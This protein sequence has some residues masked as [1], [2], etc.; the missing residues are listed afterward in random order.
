MNLLPSPPRQPFARATLGLLAFAAIVHL[1]YQIVVGLDRTD[2]GPFETVLARAVAGH[3][4]QGVG[5]SGFY[6]PFGGE[7]PSVLIHAP[8]Y[9]RMVAVLAWPLVQLGAEPLATV[10][11]SGRLLAFLGTLLLMACGAWLVR[12]DGGSRRAGW[13]AIGLIAASP[14]L[15][16]LA[17]ML[18]PDTL[19]VAFQTLGAWLVLQT[20]WD[21]QRAMPRLLLAYVAFALAFGIKQQNLTSA[22]VC[23]MLLALAWWRGRLKLGPIVLGH[24]AAVVVVAADLVIENLLTGGR[25]YHSVFVYPGGPFRDLNYAGWVHVRSVFNITAR[26][27]VGLI[28]LTVACLWATREVVLASIRAWFRPERPESKPEARKSPSTAQLPW[29]RTIQERSF[30]ALD[31]LDAV[32][33]LFLLVEVVA[34][35]PLCLFNAGAAANYALQATIFA[36]V[37][38]ARRIDPLLDWAVE[39]PWRLL[40]MALAMVALLMADVRWVLQTASIRAKDRQLIG[41]MMAD[42]DV[43]SCPPEARYFV[44]WQ[45]MNRLFGRP[46]MI[47]DDWLY[48]AFERIG[49]AEPRESWLLEALTEGPIRQVVVPYD[50]STVPGVED[51]LPEL[52]YREIAR[53]GD[54]GVWQRY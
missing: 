5:P 7:N 30:Q 8:L 3:F 19:G 12:V 27:W 26:R 14:I 11:Y 29:L 51:P 31:N 2:V 16:N 39:R 40:P 47:H 34:L 18:R 21:R 25:M 36:C 45:H 13:I 23:S 37:L 15:S 42:A 32:L 50:G 44:I 20:L 24:V 52:G 22:A 41:A 33:L 35:V 46:D 54:V 48:G 10:L 49:A 9:Y 53:F 1:G 6:G 17:T 43:S 4:D 28:A 38:V